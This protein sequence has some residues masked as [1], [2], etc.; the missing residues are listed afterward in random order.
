MVKY[1]TMSRSRCVP[2]QEEDQISRLQEVERGGSIEDHWSH[3]SVSPPDAV[4]PVPSGRWGG[5][6]VGGGSA[7]FSLRADNDVFDRLATDLQI[8]HCTRCCIHW[9]IW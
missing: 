8:S 7:M 9:Y 5:V 4:D 6:L 1:V 3:G 2:R